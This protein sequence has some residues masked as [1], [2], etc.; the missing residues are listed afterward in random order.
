MTCQTQTEN[1]YLKLAVAQVLFHFLQPNLG[2]LLPLVTS[3]LLQWPVVGTP[4]K[5]TASKSTSE[6]VD[7][8]P[9]PM[10]KFDNGREILL[11]T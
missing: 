6:K 9:K 1:G 7:L 5:K 4:H 8:A 2:S 10:V 11:T 3:T